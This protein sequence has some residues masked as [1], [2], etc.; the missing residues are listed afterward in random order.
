MPWRLPLLGIFLFCPLSLGSIQW[1]AQAVAYLPSTACLFAALLGALHWV[2]DG[3]R[4]GAWACVFFVTVGLL[5][6]ER[7]VFYPFVILALL[8]L[9]DQDV[10]LLRRVIAV[11][12]R[13]WVLL[14][15]LAVVTA[16]FLMAHF[17]FALPSETRKRTPRAPL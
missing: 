5:I 6:Q 12:R 17:V 3:R 8:V 13:R 11:V 16:A 2:Q 4:L 14:L 7:A 10:G 1:W 15:G 9:L